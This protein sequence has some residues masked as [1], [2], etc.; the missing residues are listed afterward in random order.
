MTSPRLSTELPAAPR[1][2]PRGSVAV[3]QRRVTDD[4]SLVEAIVA[5]D[6]PAV[7]E[8]FDRYAYV[9]RGV[10][11]RALGGTD[12]LDDLMQEAFLTIVRRCHTLRDPEALRSFVV[13]VAIRISRNELRKRALRR[14]IGLEEV[15][16]P[17]VTPEHDPS[18]AEA[19]RRVYAVL[20]RLDTEARLA[21]VVRHLE[22]Y[23]LAEAADICSCSLATLKRRLAKAEKCFEAMSRN[24]PVLKRLLEDG[25]GG[26]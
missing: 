24:D 12:E 19:V 8:L 10:F 13:S 25:G 17:P 26:P 16:E 5:G 6:G 2:Q 14:F 23:E 9:V 15:V 11:I 3:L 20:R 4:A 22:G 18:A 7:A 1:A 21:F